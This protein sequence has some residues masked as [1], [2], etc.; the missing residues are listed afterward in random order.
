MTAVFHCSSIVA[1][2][3]AFILSLYLMCNAKCNSRL[4]F[5]D[6]LAMRW[7][8]TF[9]SIYRSCY[10][11]NDLS[12]VFTL[13][14]GFINLFAIPLFCIF[15]VKVDSFSLYFFYFFKYFS[16]LLVLFFIF[17]QCF[18]KQIAMLTVRNIS[19]FQFPFSLVIILFRY[20]IE[21]FRISGLSN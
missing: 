15:S 3:V 16:L 2:S 11:S 17:V 19:P 21:W 13:S 6:S 14:K 1:L 12:L 7:Y 10:K 4:I 9:Y 5:C 20:K 18:W 8:D